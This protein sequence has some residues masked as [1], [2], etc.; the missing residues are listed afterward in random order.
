MNTNIVVLDEFKLKIAVDTQILAYLVDKTYPSL[1]IFFEYLFRCPFVDIVCSRFVTY[2]FIGI[3]KQEH[4]LRAIHEKSTSQK[5]TMNFS[6]VL[7][8]KNDWSASELRYEDVYTDITKKV[9]ADLKIINDDFGIYYSEFELHK[10]L[11]EPHTEL[12]LSSKLSKEDSLVILSSIFPD[13]IKKEEHIIFFTNDK[14]FYRAFCGNEKER[15]KEIDNVFETH[16]LKHPQVFKL[17]DIKLL[18]GDPINLL[19]TSETEEL[20]SFVQ[21]FIKEQI[22]IKTDKLFLGHTIRCEANNSSNLFC[23]ELNIDFELNQNIFIVVILKD[24]SNIY[25]ISTPLSDFWNYSKIENY[26]YKTTDK[27]KS[28][29]SIKISDIDPDLLSV[30]SQTGNYVFVHPHSNLL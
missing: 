17:N 11:W 12:V 5:G 2:E 23:F 8:Y 19:E 20:I 7:R 22:G 29:I 30:I 28:R 26:P 27:I 13:A 10:N 25:S 24:L 4:Y 6:S 21:S 18:D 9:N 14:Q 3:R 15:M 1:N 16:N